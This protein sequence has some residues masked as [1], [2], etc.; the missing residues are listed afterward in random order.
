MAKSTS[1]FRSV[2]S[3][4]LQPGFYWVFYHQPYIA[5]FHLSNFTSSSIFWK[6]VWIYLWFSTWD[7]KTVNG[8]VRSIFEQC[9]VS[10]I[11][12]N[13]YISL[14][15]VSDSAL[16][17]IER[18]CHQY[19][20]GG[21]NKGWSYLRNTWNTASAFTDALRLM[22]SK[23]E[24]ILKTWLYLSTKPPKS[25]ISAISLQVTLLKTQMF[26]AKLI[27]GVFFWNFCDLFG[28][29]TVEVLSLNNTCFSICALTIKK[30]DSFFRASSQWR[31]IYNASFT[32]MH[33][34]VA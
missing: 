16:E 21:T 4:S 32:K 29:E 34:T 10:S 3:E 1:D 19:P 20:T 12:S 33:E 5:Y 6:E 15:K 13:P 23:V 28:I 7:E 9:T 22:R 31:E 8:F 24:I 26:Q 14:M 11:C 2:I 27:Y 25:Q 30:P 18:L 17:S